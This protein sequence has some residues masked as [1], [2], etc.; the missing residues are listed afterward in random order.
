MMR[1]VSLTAV[2]LLVMSFC[3]CAVDQRI[4]LTYTPFLNAT[5]GRGALQIERPDIASV[6]KNEKGQ[7]VIGTVTNAL[8]AKIGDTVTNDFPGDWLALALKTEL[9]GSGYRVILVEH[10]QGSSTKA[11]KVSVDRLWV[12]QVRTFATNGAEAVLSLNITVM[13]YGRFVDLIPVSEKATLRAYHGGTARQ[14]EQALQM[15]I[16]ASMRQAVPKIIRSLE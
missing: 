2:T 4:G 11:L 14:K 3:G 1:F 9:E 5:G 8:G 6:Q 13:K 16:Q 10:L 12:D 7:Y 15:A